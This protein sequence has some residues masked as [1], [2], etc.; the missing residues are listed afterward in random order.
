MQDH[1]DATTPGRSLRCGRLVAAARTVLVAAMIA[2][3]LAGTA[4]G[5]VTA[6]ATAPTRGTLYSDGQGGRF[7]LGGQWLYRA[8]PTDVGQTAGWWRPIPSTDGWSAVSVPNAYNAGDFSS[9]SMAG[10]VGW[11]RRDFTLPP[12]AFARYVPRAAR[13]WI[14]RF[15]SVNYRATVWLNGRRLGSHTGA[16]L[17]FEFDLTGLH[18]GVNHLVVWVDN[19]RTA[20]DLPP[21]PGGWWN[22]GG[23]LR[24]VYLRAVAAVDIQRAQVRP[25]LPCPT[26]AATIDE[27]A[28]LRNLTGSRQTVHLHGVY[29]NATLDFGSVTLGP[30]S[31]ATVHAVVRIA[32]PRLWSIGRPFLYRATMVLSDRRGRQ[33]GRYFTYSGIRSIK[34]TPDGRL[35]LNGR[36]LNLRGVALQEQDIAQGAALDSAHLA[37]L[38]GWVR[39]LGATVIRAHYP[40]DPRILEMADRYG[41]LV[42]DEVP[43]YQVDSKYLGQPGWQA[44]ALSILH[45]NILD[46]Q[47]HPSVMVWSIA[48]E[49][50]TPATAGERSYIAHAAA[51]AHRLDPTRP[52]GMATSDWPGVACQA[53]YAPLDVV[54]F[55][56]YFGWYDAGGGLNDDRDA[57]SPF[58]DSWRACYPD[59]ALLITEF[60]FEANRDGPVEERGTYAFQA[61][62]VAYHLGVFASKSWLSGAIY[63]DLQD[64]AVTPGWTG[65]DPRPDP[66][67]LQKGLFDLQGHAKPAEPVL[68]SIYHHTQQIGAPVH[69]RKR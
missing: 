69:S 23:L 53:A 58:L 7:L 36:L 37:R 45:D 50:P 55:N 61:D 2:A 41:I 60:G 5:Q 13:R 32:R 40:L 33:L 16:Y 24:E 66:P 28:V 64:F 63:W 44:R 11:Y 26:C 39:R 3:A 15:E 35:T 18:A 51:L 6:P 21:S 4:Y 47:N 17:P 25:L 62:A 31:S 30:R 12:T 57:L 54:G 65:G 43:V 56:E 59:K 1:P 29:G 20:G 49:L 34:V 22:F 48:N 38:I 14:V 10:Y 52:V 46:N 68:T 42:W 9:S 67:F 19:R 27:Q 8:D